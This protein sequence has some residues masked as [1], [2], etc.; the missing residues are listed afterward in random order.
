[1]CFVSPRVTFLVLVCWQLQSSLVSFRT[2][3]ESFAFQ[4]KDA[5][6]SNP[7]FRAQFHRMCLGAGVDPL[8]CTKP[9]FWSQVLGLGDF[10]FELSVQLVDVCL[11]TRALNGGLIEMQEVLSILNRRY[12]KQGSKTSI[13]LDDLVQAIGKLS[14]LGSG[15]TILPVTAPASGGS[16]SHS[17]ASAN[18]GRHLIKSVPLE[19]QTDHL[20]LMALAAEGE[21]TAALA[22]A[23][24][25]KASSGGAA[26]SASS[27]SAALRPSAKGC[28]RPSD[29][30]SKLGWSDPRIQSCLG[31]LLE[32]GMVWIDV[33]PATGEA[34]Y[35][36]PSM[37]M[38]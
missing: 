16:S 17:S 3:L 32:E 26:T 11:S 6:Q 29:V 20:A 2:N 4:Y 19:I 5:I 27:S 30:R 10:Y 25:S 24:G 35:W 33:H 31:L 7:L 36:M 21:D 1:M 23:G 22:G 28:I 13:T 9:G 8:A 12:E 37:A 15:F 14:C 18:L 38:Q 34:E